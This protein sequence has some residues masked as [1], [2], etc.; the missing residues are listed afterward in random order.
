MKNKRIK[1]S[2]TKKKEVKKTKVKTEGLFCSNKKCKDYGRLI[3]KNIVGYGHDRNGK[4]KYRCNTC[5]KVFTETKLTIFYR[6]RITLKQIITICHLLVERVSIRGMSR[7]T[8]IHQNT[9]SSLLSDMAE[10]CRGVT[11]FLIKEVEL[12]RL[13][14]DELWTFVK[15]NKRNLGGKVISQLSKVISGSSLP[16]SPKPSSI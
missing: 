4:Q 1:K 16:K 14:I 15:K 10:H 7:I 3:T 6:R 13:E 12:S 9:I 2:M 5:G 11:E 8:G